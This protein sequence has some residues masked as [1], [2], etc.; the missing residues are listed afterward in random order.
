MRSFVESVMPGLAQL[1]AKMGVKKTHTPE[2]L[3]VI[4]EA[5]I[6]YAKRDGGDSSQG[7]EVGGAAPDASSGGKKKTRRGGKKKK[8]PAAEPATKVSAGLDYSKSEDLDLIQTR[9][10]ELDLPFAAEPFKG[11]LDSVLCSARAGFNHCGTPERFGALVKGV[12]DYA[13]GF[14]RPADLSAWLS[15][16]F[17]IPH[18]DDESAS[19]WVEKQQLLIQ[20]LQMAYP[21]LQRAELRRTCANCEVVASVDASPYQICAGCQ[22][23]SYCSKACQKA[24]WRSTHRRECPGRLRPQQS[25]ESV[26]TLLRAAVASDDETS[27]IEQLRALAKMECTLEEVKTCG[28]IS[29]LL[30]LLPASFLTSE[31]GRTDVPKIRLDEFDKPWATIPMMAAA[32]SFRLMGISDFNPRCY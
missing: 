20:A 32:L 26:T 8:K 4:T 15:D 6:L 30:T 16:L 29:I 10:R 3:K 7:G 22:R 19:Q 2:E 18:I 1:A 24:H 31:D 23:V 5:A 14:L 17:D 9:V 21:H 11:A 12:R 28:T 13:A 27:T 25:I